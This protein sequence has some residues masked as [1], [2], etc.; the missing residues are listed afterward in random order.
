LRLYEDAFGL[1]R[2]RL[3]AEAFSLWLGALFALLILAGTSAR[4]MRHLPRVILAGTAAALIA[5]T[6]A[7]PDGLIASKN[8][9]RWQHTG[10]ID[11]AYLQTLSADAAPAVASL[12]PALRDEALAPLAARLAEDEPWSSANLSRGRARTQLF[13][14]AGG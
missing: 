6:L 8:V 9:E 3:A 14:P 2:L 1:T 7:N 13:N 11:V 5:F 4:L 10:R 12:P